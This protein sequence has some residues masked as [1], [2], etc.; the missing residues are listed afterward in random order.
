MGMFDSV[1]FLCT[2]CGAPI[3]VQSKAG[4]CFMEV[5]SPDDVPTEIAV[6]I[7]GEPVWCPKC[8]VEFLVKTDSIPSTVECWLK[9]VS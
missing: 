6:D 3:E 4:E 8:E 7:A 1:M 2:E 5:F 9:K